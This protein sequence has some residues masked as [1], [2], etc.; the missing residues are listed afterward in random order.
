M[1]GTVESPTSE[2]SLDFTEVVIS[3]SV[4]WASGDWLV[5][6][7]QNATQSKSA[8]IASFIQDLVLWNAR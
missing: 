1:F 2:A 5:R 8:E 3:R 4:T 7:A 6:H